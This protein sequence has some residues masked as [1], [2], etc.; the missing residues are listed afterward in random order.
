[1]NK[2]VALSI[3]LISVLDGCSGHYSCA[4]FPES[5]CQDMSLV[6]KRTGATFSDYRHTS[7]NEIKPSSMPHS[8][9]E[10]SSSSTDD[11]DPLFKMPVALRVWLAPWRDE[12][13]DIETGYIYVVAERGQWL[14][15]P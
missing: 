10:I 14:I 2:Q 11:D 3:I 7:K 12:N 8:V 9:T 4:K 13:N 6:Y 15:T 1:M 5:S